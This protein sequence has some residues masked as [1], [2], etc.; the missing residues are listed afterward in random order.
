MMGLRREM[1]MGREGVA[2]VR[3]G[4][5]FKDMKMGLGEGRGLVAWF[6]PPRE[7]R[8]VYGTMYNSTTEGEM[9]LKTQWC[10]MGNSTEHI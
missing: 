1:G 3:E 9:G 7:T 2:R 4:A 5:G 6:E 8:R 10:T